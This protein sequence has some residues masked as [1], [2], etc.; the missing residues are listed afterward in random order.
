MALH[1]GASS[2]EGNQSTPALDAA[3]D[4]ALDS[5]IPSEP[6]PL[7]ASKGGDNP[8][9]AGASH[10]AADDS[11]VHEAGEPQIEATLV[12]LEDAVCPP[13]EE[14]DILGEPVCVDLSNRAP[15]PGPC[16]MST[17]VIA[18]T[19][20][21]DGFALYDYVYCDYHYDADRLL[22]VNCFYQWRNAP[23]SLA[24]KCG[25][26]PY[27]S[28]GPDCERDTLSYW[29][30]R[31]TFR[32]A[33]SAEGFTDLV[34]V[35]YGASGDMWDEQWT[36]QL[37]SRSFA[38]C[39]Y[40]E[41]AD[42]DC[43]QEVLT[44]EIAQDVVLNA[45]GWPRVP[46]PDSEQTAGSEPCTTEGS[47]SAGLVTQRCGSSVTSYEYDPDGMLRVYREGTI[48]DLVDAGLA[49]PVWGKVWLYD[50]GGNLRYIVWREGSGDGTTILAQE[51]RYQCDPADAGVPY[52]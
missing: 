20:P 28:P 40:D 27:G 15:F 23:D 24:G 29:W 49:E 46:Q 8:R 5:G 45:R 39:S 48:P 3:L 32:Y 7:D 12:Y 36:L 21:E 2:R 14:L 1:C 44:P 41:G 38:K 22:E 4:A 52:P 34:E 16:L 18:T 17:R 25:T 51:Y 26:P 9:D 37:P 30:D 31:R 33:G 10:D 6:S 19:A 50:Q 47:P 13:G 11:A 43:S 42:E 35:N